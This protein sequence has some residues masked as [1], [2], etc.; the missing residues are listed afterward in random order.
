MFILNPGLTLA[1]ISGIRTYA[2]TRRSF[3][4]AVQLSVGLYHDRCVEKNLFNEEKINVNA[5]GVNI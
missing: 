3:N 2:D 4:W 5:L 1:E